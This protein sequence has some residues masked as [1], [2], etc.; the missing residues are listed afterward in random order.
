MNAD[1]AKRQEFYIHVGSERSIADATTAFA[2]IKEKY[3]DILSQLTLSLDAQRS[4]G[5]HVWYRALVSPP[6]D[7]STAI[8]TC[9]KL[10]VAGLRWCDVVHGSGNI[11]TESKIRPDKKASKPN[12]VRRTITSP[13]DI[14][15]AEMSPPETSSHC[16]ILTARYG[17]AR[18]LLILSVGEDK[19]IFTALTVDIA[20][21]KKQAQAFISVHARGGNVIGVYNTQNEAL[22]RAYTLCPEG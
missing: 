22:S 21:A 3:S 15:L 5:D 14:P 4:P 17:G 7:S 1:V 16:T 6:M 20:K 9:K 8:A 13:S 10:Q 19:L 18:T 2:R 11:E 12:P